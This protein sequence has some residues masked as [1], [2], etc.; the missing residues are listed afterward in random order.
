MS[1]DEHLERLLREALE[2][3]R[4]PGP[5]RDLWPL[6]EARAHS[7]ARWSWLDLG[8]AAVAAVVLLMQPAWLWLLIYHL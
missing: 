3:E 4:R 5:P 6:V 2:P 7:A 8:L 1:D